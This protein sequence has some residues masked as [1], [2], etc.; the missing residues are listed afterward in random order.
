MT[1]VLLMVATDKSEKLAFKKHK[2]KNNR[3]IENTDLCFSAKNSG[4]CASC[5]VG[6]LLKSTFLY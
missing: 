5:F 1:S 6:I 3:E 4:H 2:N